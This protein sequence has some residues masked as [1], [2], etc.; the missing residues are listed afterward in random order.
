MQTPR[1]GSLMTA[2][3]SSPRSRIPRLAAGDSP[4]PLV[5][6]STMVTRSP[7]AE[8]PA[9]PIAPSPLMAPQPA[10]APAPFPMPSESNIQPSNISRSTPSRTVRTSATPSTLHQQSQAPRPRALRRA[11]RSMRQHELMRVISR[12]RVALAHIMRHQSLLR[13]Q[14]QS[15]AQQAGLAAL[16]KSLPA[17][18]AATARGSQP[19]ASQPTMCATPSASQG[20]ALL[21]D[22]LLLHLICH[23]RL[24]GMC[25]GFGR[26]VAVAVGG[27]GADGSASVVLS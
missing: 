17:T 8:N 5:T 21:R 19:C 11:L 20:S 15:Q 18:C 6:G 9:R 23:R 3:N 24:L 16:R 4:A 7:P 26:W 2:L 14:Q 10:R 12:W 27:A 25:R 1:Q 22:T 13:L